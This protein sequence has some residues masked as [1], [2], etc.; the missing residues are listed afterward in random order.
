MA[1]QPEKSVDFEEK[2]A[3]EKEVEEIKAEGEVKIEAVTDF[4][5][6]GLDSRILKV[7]IVIVSIQFKIILSLELCYYEPS[8]W[9]VPKCFS[10]DISKHL[11]I[12]EINKILDIFQTDHSKCFNYSEAYSFI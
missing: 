11:S 4:Q 5:E 9:I 7:S 8:K 6:M 10:K 1:E 3:E 2:E 12:K